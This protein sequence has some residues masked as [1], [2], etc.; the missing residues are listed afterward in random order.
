MQSKMRILS[1]HHIPNN[2][3]FLFAY[4]LL[5]LLQQEFGSFDIKILD[6]KSSR[7]AI[8][9][10]L[11]R[12][13]VFQ[14]TP[15]F[16]M[17]RARVWETQLKTHLDLD[18]NFPHFSRE[19]TLQ[20]YFSKE[21]DALVVGMDTW[22]VINGTE[23]PEFP[24]IYWLP[25]KT[26]IPKIAYGISA[27]NSDMTL[28]RQSA[29]KIESYL[30]DFD[31]IGAR[32]HFTYELVKKHRS[33]TDGLVEMIP[34]PTFTYKFVDTDVV[35]K[36]QLLGIDLNRPT[37]GLL[38]FGDD[39]LSNQILSHYKAKGYQILAMSMYNAVAD[40][41]L[42]HLLTPFEWAEAFRYLS[43]CI[44]D[45]FHGTIFCLMNQ[46]PFI[47]LEKERHLP[48]SQSKIYDLLTK[49]RLETCYKNPA[50]ENFE[51]AS[52]LALA[53]EIEASWEHI[54]KPSILPKIDVFKE[55]HAQFLQKIKIEL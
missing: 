8:Y 12:F 54:F 30:N 7:L 34:D 6:Y 1:F 10:Y 45:R 3:A 14:K 26:A 44:S 42:G 33:R 21:Y 9:E 41:N 24:N 11:K 2:G 38:F 15:L 46:T 5:E 53:D 17:M 4:S 25:K 35:S 51:I 48:K 13:K 20:E 28:V 27:Y 31:V 32:D 49:F 43:F 55:E 50:D 22:C 47:S 23:R 37:L 19:K 52:F 18:H 36:L 39:L 40:F 16:Y 29:G